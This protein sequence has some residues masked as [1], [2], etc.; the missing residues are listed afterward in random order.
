M[1]MKNLDYYPL[2]CKL[3]QILNLTIAACDPLDGLTDGV[4][5]RTDLCKPHYNLD[6]AIGE[7]YHC[8]AETSSGYGKRQTS[9]IPAQSGKVTAKGVK[10]AQTIIDGMKNS[11]GQQVYLLYQPSSTWFDAGTT[12]TSETGSW[13]LSVS[14]IGGDWVDRFLELI[15]SQSCR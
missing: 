1:A 7:S 2:P 5:S 14:G 13:E 15:D 6:K 4:I 12:Y 9:T 3:E 8:A 10:I 11:K